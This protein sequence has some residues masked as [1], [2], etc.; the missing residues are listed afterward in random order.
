MDTRNLWEMQLTAATWGIKNVEKDKDIAAEEILEQLKAL[1]LPS[2]P[3]PVEV[4]GH[5][6]RYSQVCTWSAW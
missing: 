2:L 1:G 6:W 4:K 3:D 5:K